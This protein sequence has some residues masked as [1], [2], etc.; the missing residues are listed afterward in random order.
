MAEEEAAPDASHYG[1]SKA[2]AGR[3][4]ELAKLGVV[5]GPQRVEEPSPVAPSPSAGSAW[6]A[7]G[8]TWEDKDISAKGQKALRE[9]LLASS[10]ILVGG[11]E[12][13]VKGVSSCE[14]EVRAVFSRGKRLLAFDTT[15]EATWA[16]SAEGVEVASGTLSL[17][18]DDTDSDTVSSLACNCSTC[19]GHAA[20]GT[21]GAAAALA[22]K[23]S[24]GHWRAVVRAWVADMKA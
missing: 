18:L 9:K 15:V 4:E 2:T 16:L 22:G 14:G 23:Q 7:A 20:A 5:T 8:T 6:N 21:K 11:L 12:L 3:R 24:V 19:T 17:G 1:W 13:K 10:C